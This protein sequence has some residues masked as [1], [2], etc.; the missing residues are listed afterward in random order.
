MKKFFV[1]SIILILSIMITALALALPQKT[2]EIENSMWTKAI[3]N[4]E[5]FCVEMEITCKGNTIV[6]IEPIEGVQ[7]PE[8]W[9]DPRPEEFRERLC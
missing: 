2:E 4:E 8:H 7:F 1:L 5:N 9:K 3:C 6:D